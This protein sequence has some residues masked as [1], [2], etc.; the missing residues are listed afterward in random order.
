MSLKGFFHRHLLGLSSTI[1]GI[2]RLYLG[3]LGVL[4]RREEEEEGQNV[5]V[6]MWGGGE[7]EEREK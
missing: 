5:C 7:G 3:E 4:E 6:S 1:V 2:L